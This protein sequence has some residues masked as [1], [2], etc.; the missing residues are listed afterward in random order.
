MKIALTLLALSLGILNSGLVQAH[1]PQAL[2]PLTEITLADGRDIVADTKGRVVYSFDPDAPGVSNCYD[3]CAKTWPPVVVST[4]A[5]L[6]E[7]MGVTKRKTGELQL[8]IDNKPLYFY[9]GDS[10]P[11]DINGDGIGNVWH[12]VQ[13]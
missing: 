3:G 13:D 9:K 7:P 1:D 10:K 4:G 6:S 2:A 5:G 8:T 11:N 12:I